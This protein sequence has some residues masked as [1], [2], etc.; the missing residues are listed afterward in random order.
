MKNLFKVAAVVVL[1]LGFGL[2]ANAQDRSAQISASAKVVDALSVTKDQDLNF[3]I[4]MQGVNKLVNSQGGVADTDAGTNNTTDVKVGKF[5]V[6]AGAGSSVTLSFVVPSNLTGP[7]GATM[8]IAFNEDENGADATTV[9]YG[10]ESGNQTKLLV[11]EGNSIL[12]PDTQIGGKTATY[13]WVGG[14]VKPSATQANGS[15]TGSVTLTASYN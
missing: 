12:F 7:S 13:V 4:V 6:N 3:G 5:L 10:A 11:T 15:Y 1:S 2:A 8:P 14:V 9:A